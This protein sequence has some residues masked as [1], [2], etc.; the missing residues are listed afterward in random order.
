[1]MKKTVGTVAIISSLLILTA[2]SGS[3]TAEESYSGGGENYT[4]VAPMPAEAP[5]APMM[6]SGGVVSDK[7]ADGSISSTTSV[8]TQREII[9]VGN[10]N[11][12]VENVVSAQGDVKRLTNEYGGFISSEDTQ[13][14]GGEESTYS[15]ITSQIPADKLDEYIA[16]VSKLGE[17]TAVN[18][19]SQD[20]TAV[21]VDLDARINALQSS[22]DRLNELMSQ[23]GS[24]EELLAVETSISQRQAELDS[25]QA[26]RKTLG[27]QVALSTISVYLSSIPVVVPIESDG[28]IA[29]FQTGWAN[30][31]TNVGKFVTSLGQAAPTVL[32]VFLPIALMILL[33]V[34]IVMK[35]TKRKNKKAAEI[36]PA[37]SDSE[38]GAE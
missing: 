30:L 11:V 24:V 19:S 36:A 6:D 28:F 22:I 13:T 4:E 32:F 27:E 7:A 33:I 14:S 38:K 3:Q 8:V 18:V 34:A 35:T 29:G 2:C 25:L 37:T 5:G 23:A 12:T 26:Q 15:T 17:V 21:V 20:V 31:Q 16:D 10:M 9:R 1:M